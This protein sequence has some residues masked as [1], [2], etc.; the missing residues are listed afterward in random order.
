MTSHAVPEQRGVVARKPH[1]TWPRAATVAVSIVAWAAVIGSL[2]Q[3][4]TVTVDAL[5]DTRER[6]VSYAIRVT[7]DFDAFGG[8]F[9][10]IG[11]TYRGT[12]GATLAATQL[13][14]VTV[15]FIGVHARRRGLRSLAAAGM[16]AWVLLWMGNAA[17]AIALAPQAAGVWIHAAFVLPGAVCVAMYIAWRMPRRAGDG[18]NKA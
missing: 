10:A 14:I 15:S 5:R 18:L 2:R 6:N 16:F 8:R 12:G 3:V 11:Q 4:A 9:E 13:T 17:I 7:G 1:R